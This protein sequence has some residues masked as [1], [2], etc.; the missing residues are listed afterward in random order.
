MCLA[1]WVFHEDRYIRDNP[2]LFRQPMKHLN[3]NQYNLNSSY[4]PL[5]HKLV[6]LHT[7][8][9]SKTTYWVVYIYCIILRNFRV[10]LEH[11]CFSPFPYT[12]LSPFGFSKHLSWSKF[13]ALS[14]F[15]NFITKGFGQLWIFSVLGCCIFPLFFPIGYE[16]TE[17]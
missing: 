2:Q 16:I 3:C 1:S 10:S 14:V 11:S 15:Q 6:T 12:L 5:V 8:T 17:I 7:Q 13:F 9:I 4:S